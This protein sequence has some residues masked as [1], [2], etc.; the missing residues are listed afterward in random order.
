M[1]KINW[2][3]WNKETFNKAAKEITRS[4]LTIQERL[5]KDVPFFAFPY[6]KENE[7]IQNTVY[8]EFSGAFSVKMGL[9]TLKSDI[10]SLP[11]IEM[12]YF[13]KN[14]LFFQIENPIFNNYIR[15]RGMLRSIR[16]L[17]RHF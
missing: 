13:S 14:N 5:K 2:H 7:Q 17:M 1:Q 3:E 4:K 6:G 16:E 15:W 12:Y 8:D 11:R 10:Y 9:A